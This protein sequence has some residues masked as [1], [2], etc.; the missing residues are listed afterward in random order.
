MTKA[1]TFVEIDVPYC[2]NIY[3]TS[4]CT[5]ALGVTGDAKCFNSI[6]TCQDRENYNDDPVALR[7]AIPCDYLPQDVF[8]IPSIVS[9]G[10]SP[11]T[12]SL[13][14][15]LGERAS[16][17]IVLR[18]HPWSDT[19]PAGDKYYAERDYDP[20]ALGTFFGKFR[21]RQPFLRG[22]ALRLIRGF[23]GQALA[24]ME[25]RH[26]VIDSFDGPRPDGTYSITAKDVLKLA[27]GDRAQAPQI[28]N[29]RLNAGINSS[30]TAATLTPTGIGNDE[31]PASGYLNLGGTEIVSFTRSGDALTITRAQFNTLGVAHAAGDRVQV[32]LRYAAADPADIIS[33]LLITYAGVDED[34]I[35]LT[36][37]QTETA[38]FLGNVY[39]ALIA[40]PVAV[41]D[42]CAELIEQAALVVWWD[43]VN[44]F[45]RLQV[46][47]NILTTAA[48][49]DNNNVLEGTLRTAEQP[50]TR[51]SQVW[52]YFVQRSPFE[53]VDSEDNY[54]AV[55][56]VADLE[57]QG[58][59]GS[60]AIKKIFSRWVGTGG[61]SV[62]TRMGRL[63][64]GRFR[65]PPRKFNFNVF[66]EGVG[67][68]PALGGGYRVKGWP[69]QDETGAASEAPVQITRLNPGSDSYQLEAQ[70][71][72]FTGFDPADVLNRTIIIDTPTNDIN[73]R[74]L[75]DTL[76]SAPTDADVLGGVNLTV[77]IASGTTIG[78]SSASSPA[79]DIGSWPVGFP[80][81]LV[82]EGRI[83]GKGGNGGAS[84]ASAG[85]VGEIGGTA[86]Y[87]RFPITLTYTGA[88]I[89]GGGGG[90]G[91]GAPVAV[92]SISG[93]GGGGGAG[94]VP[95]DGGGCGPPAGGGTPQ[96]GS[97]GTTEAG[98]SG[99]PVLGNL[100]PY[101]FG[102]TGGGPGLAGG[103]GNAPRFG[104]GSA[105][106]GG[107]AGNAID[108]T[109]YTT[110]VGTVG[111]YRG[112]RIN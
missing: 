104:A 107:A 90:A 3:G 106:A 32:C 51:L 39:T 20:Y 73:L 74:D 68:T 63:Q 61:R 24:D 33:D 103:N 27:D 64:L 37:W 40:E 80:I 91:G 44:Q 108:G 94:T 85:G 47:R 13:G 42:L 101:S 110:V 65:D 17:T 16:L 11:G 111:D 70:E 56:I 72:L 54:A 8:A 52:I 78:A 19:G 7:F 53:A 18:D 9:V 86:L 29:G 92:G 97:A 10:F 105:G 25:T 5:A 75:H 69:I 46:L 35:P 31:Y 4:P 28:S 67:I 15:D 71:V 84:S 22:R 96:P 26:Y 45:V 49:F 88:E 66:R 38:A 82:V 1:L 36:S 98:N 43:D 55:E 2:A 81:T 89:W 77:N 59:Y 99:G 41:S 12:V 30:V 6:R 34:F 93:G 58:D 95:G 60:A 23:E 109:S 83:Q 50:D 21:A 100:A 87:T 48:V 102:G 14:V 112:P 76:F 62:A 57:A 79:F